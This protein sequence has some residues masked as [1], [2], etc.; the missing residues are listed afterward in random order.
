MQ[1][2]CYIIHY[3]NIAC[4]L[5]Y[6]IIEFGDIWFRRT[7]TKSDLRPT[8]SF[9]SLVLLCTPKST[10]RSSGDIWLPETT[11]KSDLRPTLTLSSLVLLCTATSTHRSS[12]STRSP[13]FSFAFYSDEYTPQC[14]QDAL[15][16]SNNEELMQEY[17]Y[18]TY[19]FN[20]ACKLFYFIIEFGDIWFRRTTT[21]SDL[22]P[23][24]ILSSLVLLCTAT[25]THRSS[26]RM[27]CRQVITKS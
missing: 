24:L 13:Q 2:Y 10:H 6:F 14:L 9:S 1:E 7:T 3:F 26:Y 18:I 21:K 5:S 22:R 27:R 11:T 8:L 19:Y 16:A 20:I 23:T 12:Y 17:Y 4:K 25:S 15:P